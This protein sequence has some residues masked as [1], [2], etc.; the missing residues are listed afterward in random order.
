[1]NCS[2]FLISKNK[3]THIIWDFNGTL[4]DDVSAAVRANNEMLRRRG[5]KEIKDMDIF[6]VIADRPMWDFYREMGFDLEAE[7]YREVAAEW[8][9]LYREYSASASLFP[10][11]IE[12]L[13][14][15]SKMG[16]SQIVLSASEENILRDQLLSLG[17]DGF[18]TEILGLETFHTIDKTIIT[19]AWK[20]RN[21]DAV[22]IVIGDTENDVKTAKIL[23]CDCILKIGG[24]RSPE[25]L[26]KHGYMVIES[27]EELL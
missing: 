2:N 13:Q 17:I 20:E 27:F 11:A 15:F 16:I 21:P 3:Y 12:C 7:D 22:P 6:Y 5:L 18:F 8:G 4:L 25:S 14:R 23:S 24:H 26:K 10:G 1:M 9:E 19:Q